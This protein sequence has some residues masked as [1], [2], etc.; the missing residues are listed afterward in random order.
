V[1]NINKA[2]LI[3]AID[4]RGRKGGMEKASLASLKKILLDRF[5]LKT[6]KAAPEESYSD[7]KGDSGKVKKSP[8]RK[9]ASK[10]KAD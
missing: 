5:G 1:D 9:V 2:L 10:S 7:E 4:Y 3:M 6:V 8:L